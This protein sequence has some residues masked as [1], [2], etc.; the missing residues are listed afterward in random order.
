[1]NRSKLAERVG[2]RRRR[3]LHTQRAREILQRVIP[4]RIKPTELT[5]PMLSSLA[6][7]Y[8]PDPTSCHSFNRDGTRAR[9][10]CRRR[11][12]QTL[13]IPVHR[14]PTCAP[15]V[16]RAFLNPDRPGETANTSSPYSHVEPRVYSYI[17][18][19]ILR[20]SVHPPTC[21]VTDGVAGVSYSTRQWRDFLPST[22]VAAINAR[23]ARVDVSSHSPTET[24]FPDGRQR[25]PYSP[26]FSLASTS[27]LV[28]TL[29][30]GL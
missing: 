3:T 14:S 24:F 18:F 9:R 20:Y 29:K 25:L 28:C 26:S 15:V 30:R 21:P 16:A 17:L 12:L 27:L 10:L 13:N 7:S 1:M 23:D 19:S 2:M 5:L 6:R 8:L 11:S 4:F 22:R